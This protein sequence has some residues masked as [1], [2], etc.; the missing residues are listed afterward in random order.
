MDWLMGMNQ[1]VN[2]IEDNL[3]D[4]IS[5]LLAAKFVCCSVCEFQRIF[6]FMAKIPLSEYIRRRRL[7]LAAHDIQKNKDK[8][9]DIAIK[10]GYDSAAAFSRAFNNLHGTTPISARNSGVML[11]TYPRISFKLTIQGV[12]EMDYKI[13]EKDALQVIGINRKMS[14][15]NNAH[16]KDIPKFWGDFEQSRLHDKLK[17]YASDDIVFAITTYTDEPDCFWY[18][19]AVA[20]NDVKNT[21]NYDMLTIPAGSYAVFEVPPKDEADIGSFTMRIFKEWLPATG[22]KLTGGAEIECCTKNGTVIWLPIA[23]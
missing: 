2:Y 15:K 5:Y 9:V 8:I 19:L 13:I 21:D 7:T 10:Y 14:T 18:M 12:E 3:D 1:A 16:W 11:K 22:Y 4:E 6:S 17:A 20:Y 23:E